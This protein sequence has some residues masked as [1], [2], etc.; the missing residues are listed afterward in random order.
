MVCFYF[1]ELVQCLTLSHNNIKE[2]RKRKKY[3]TIGTSSDTKCEQK[4]IEKNIIIIIFFSTHD[5]YQAPV[6][7]CESY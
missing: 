7:G 4:P 6:F 2:R 1:A 5:I 3:Y